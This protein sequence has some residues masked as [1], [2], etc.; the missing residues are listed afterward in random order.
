MKREKNL[1]TSYI[2]PNSNLDSV[3][4]NPT[5]KNKV[6]T[7]VRTNKKKADTLENSQNALISESIENPDIF[8]LN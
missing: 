7:W 5:N 2:Q 6:N 4:V 3:I 1:S 8:I